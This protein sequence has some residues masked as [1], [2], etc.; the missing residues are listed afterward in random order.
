MAHTHRI[1]LNKKQTKKITVAINEKESACVKVLHYYTL[2]GNYYKKTSSSSGGKVT[3][4]SP[5]KEG[6]KNIVF[7]GLGS[8][9][10]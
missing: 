5:K 3:K 10:S 6:W 8:S 4:K 9:R 2:I 1:K 7:E